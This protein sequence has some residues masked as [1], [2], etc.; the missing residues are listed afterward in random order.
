MSDQTYDVL[1]VGG[2][3]AGIEAALAA[4]RVGCSAV[5]LT[6][7]LDTIGQMSCNPAIGGPAKGH[8]VREIDAL[9]GLMGINTDATSIQSRMLNLAKGSSVRAPRAQCDKKAYQYRAK[10]VLEGTRNLDIKQTS[11]LKIVVKEGTVV[12]VQTS[13]GE[14]FHTGAVVITSGTFLRGQLH[15]GEISVTGGRM[16]D[17]SSG[18]SDSIRE[19]GISV[20]RFKTGTPC[21]INRRSIDFEKCEIQYGDSPS[22]RFS[23]L[24]LPDSEKN[25]IFTLNNATFNSEPVP[26]WVTRTNPETHEIIRRNI[27][28][29]PLHSGRIQGVGPRYCPSIED[30]VFRFA[31]KLGH[32]LFLEPEGLHTDEF[33]VNGISTSLPYDVQLEFLRTIAGLENAAIMRP[34]YAVEY[35]Y[36]PPTQLHHTMESKLISGLFFAGQVNGTSGYE[37]AAAQGLMAGAN[38]A[39]KVHEAPPFILG[40]G[41]AFIG[42]LIDDLVTKGADE[43][44]RMFTSR[45]EAR[46]TLRHDNADQRLTPR[47][48]AVGLI[49]PERWDLF[50]RKSELLNKA[51]QVA[52][53]SGIAGKPV[54]HL[55]KQPRFTIDLLPA[56]IRCIVPDEIW[57]LIEFDLKNEGYIQ[58]QSALNK[59]MGLKEQQC[60]P[61][62]TDFARIHGLRS[63][64]R[65]KL[66]AIRPSTLGQAQRVSGITP[67]DISIIALWLSHNALPGDDVFLRPNPR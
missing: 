39:L 10:A 23:Y 28:R 1:V 18:L 25:E 65:E 26:C 35:D 40:R 12:G 33:Y 47:G 37:E 3:H 20:G 59:R 21:R 64:T 36:F 42:V 9:G 58:R 4:N 41:E 44:Y 61:I 56:S 57:E 2:G 17:A 66:S 11:V 27:H 54:A 16:A 34:G 46:L 8:I 62:E 13:T 63:E 19:F 38:A 5:L 24:P 53:N 22:P 31:D 14:H 30:K 55:L 45:A 51:R 15:I 32:Q 43:P 60:I 48:H 52:A 67:A 7:N 29:S 49:T 50:Q 6:Q